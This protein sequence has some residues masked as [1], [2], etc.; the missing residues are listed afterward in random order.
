MGPNQFVKSR[1]NCT[2][3]KGVENIQIRQTISIQ[4][5]LQIT[6]KEKMSKSD[7]ETALYWYGGVMG[8]SFKN[9]MLQNVCR[10]RTW[11]LCHLICIIGEIAPM[12]NG[13]ILLM[14]PF[15][16]RLSLVC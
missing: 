11:R 6:L 4:T 16:I 15:R 10:L 5:E 7:F 12:A 14:Q 1:F 8:S 2:S 9:A 13:E 3:H